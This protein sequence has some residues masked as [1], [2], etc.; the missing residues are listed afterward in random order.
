MTAIS[1]HQSVL[2]ETSSRDRLMGSTYRCSNRPTRLFAKIHHRRTPKANEQLENVQ[3]PS[4]G[5]IAIVT[6]MTKQPRKRK[7]KMKTE[8]AASVKK[9]KVNKSEKAKELYVYY[10][11][12]RCAH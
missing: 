11:Y 4:N 3:E 12:H 5:A 9:A 10:W 1:V 6:P 8:E 2:E 7:A